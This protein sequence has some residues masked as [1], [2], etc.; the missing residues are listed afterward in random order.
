[1]ISVLKQQFEKSLNIP[2]V[3]KVYSFRWSDFQP[4]QWIY[5]PEDINPEYYAKIKN[6]G[7]REFEHQIGRL[8]NWRK[9]VHDCS[10]LNGDFI[11]FGSWKGF[12]LMWIAYFMERDAIFTKK[13][14][15][16]DGFIGLPYADGGF[17][18]GKFANTSLKACR[19]NVL[20]DN[21][22]YEETKKNIFIEKFLYSQ[23]TDIIDYLRK[24]K[25]TK[26]CFI[27]IDCDVSQSAREIF[28]I[29]TERNLIADKA[30]ILFDD[31]GIEPTLRDEIKR[32]LKRQQPKWNIKVHSETAITKNYIFTKK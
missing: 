27:H 30:Y 3:Y 6:L 4:L 2:L 23:K 16:L 5:R 1:M 10:E 12:S 29:L 24:L 22:L 21:G 13:L 19:R 25:V 20:G 15:G 31:Y 32:F 11:E 18:K 8:T 28:T 9:I 17:R 26:L 14:I 7:V